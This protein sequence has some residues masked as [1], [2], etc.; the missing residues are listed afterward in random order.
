[1]DALLKTTEVSKLIGATPRHVQRMAKNGVLHCEVRTNGRGRPICLFPLSSLPETAQRRYFEEHRALVPAPAPAGKTGKAA[2]KG[3]AQTAKA[4]PVA[5]SMEQY[6][7]E[8]RA[9][10]SYWLKLVERWQDYRNRSGANKAQCDEAFVQLCQL[11]EPERSISVGVLY[12]HWAAVREGDW[13][14]LV[15]K[16]GK[17]RLGQTALDERC[18]TAF[19]TFYL[20]ES[21]HPIPRCMKLTEVWAQ[22]NAPEALPLPAY[23]SFYRVTKEV[24]YAVEVLC[25]EGEKAYYD[26]CSPYIR[27]ELESIAS[28]DFWIGDTHT[29]DVQSMAPDGTLHRLHLSAWLDA[30]S[31]LFVGWYLT[32][33]PGSQATLYALERG[34]KQFGV[35]QNVY[36]D[37]G[38]EFLTYDFGGRG[39][40]AK[41]VLAHG[42]KPFA[43]PGVLERMGIKMTNAIVRNARAKLIERRFEDFK[44]FIS[45][46][47]PTYT[48]GT[49]VE[50]PN[51]LKFVLKDG[52][53][54]PTD[55]EVISAVDVLIEGYMNCE[56]YG[57]SV[58]EDKGKRCIDVWQE[59]LPGGV[60]RKADEAS[61]RLMLMRTSKP[62]TVGR[63]GVAVTI[64]GQKIEYY[65]EELV[66]LY[67]K[68]KVYVRFDPQDLTV[69]RAYTE[70]DRFLMEL[71]QNP[72]TASYLATQE[73]VAEL[74]A[75]KRRAERAVHDFADKLRLPE[76][77]ER[78]LALMTAFAQ[79]NVDELRMA[80]G[81][82]LIQLVHSEPE[83][84]LLRAVGDIDIRQMT[85]NAIRQK[86]GLEDENV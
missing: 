64:K 10:I 7:A 15:D 14:A 1:M 52:K 60:M 36:V 62:A 75:S 80:P 16:R 30:R 70:D 22:Q 41:K 35:P 4:T 19:L 58:A 78:S 18:R 6:T 50:K 43:P 8:E 46:L 65:T 44:N 72:H 49:V 11:E 25:R 9:E 73:Q 34:C 69:V 63:R 21:R 3:K 57:G 51:K 61:L 47:F 71:P 13:D 83:T 12:R 39:H 86:G 29:L 81:A 5:K 26:K 85:D 31:G 17:A 76:D 20:D 45:R 82:K 42:M 32:D 59:R 28:N 74:Q 33:N 68:K 67:M 66:R 23:A 27:R 56:N 54:I 40:R 55:D 79:H 37:N 38:R 53:H 84:P 77:P 24:P 2:K 48:G